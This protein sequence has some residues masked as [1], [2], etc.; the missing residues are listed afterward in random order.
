MGGMLIK[1]NNVFVQKL[2]IENLS[3]VTFVS[4][5]EDKGSNK[6]RTKRSAILKATER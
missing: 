3:H 2:V 6:I 5:G 1:G 4:L